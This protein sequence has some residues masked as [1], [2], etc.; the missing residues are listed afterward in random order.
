[1]GVATPLAASPSLDRVQLVP[2]FFDTELIVTPPDNPVYTPV[3]LADL[4][5]SMKEHGQLSPAWLCPS[6]DLPEDRRLCL[7]G[8]RRT[9]VARMLGIQLWAF[10]LGRFVPEEERIR[11]T[12]QHNHFRRVMSRHEMA[13]RAARFIELTNCS[14]SEAATLLNVS[15]PTLSRAFGERRIPAGLRPRAEKLGLS[16]R[17][18]VA[19]VPVALMDQA[20]RYAE[21]PGPDGKLPTR[22]HVS[23]FIARLKK[24]GTAKPPKVRGITLRI[25]GRAVSLS[26]GDKDSVATVTEDLKAIIARLGQNA[27][28]APDGWP[29]LFDESR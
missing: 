25:N 11:L 6:P 18:L 21:T 14:Q 8:N 2:K 3:M 10:D 7:E 19:S 29:F 1:M 15:G 23:Q 16:I 24:T 26:L 12:F 5:A 22:D 20:I 4:L 9:A 13:E 27:K 28:M 17:S